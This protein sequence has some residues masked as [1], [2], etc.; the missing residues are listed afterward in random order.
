MKITDEFLE[1]VE[2][3][4]SKK[5]EE[6]QEYLK[7][8]DWRD[9]P[10]DC[11]RLHVSAVEDA[12]KSGGFGVFK[13]HKYPEEKPLI[14]DDYVVRLSDGSIRKRWFFP[15]IESFECKHVLEWFEFD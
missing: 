15:E 7:T 6:T 4:E 11:K 1:K 2:Q 9:P 3:I 10:E 14:R 13:I 12:L 5:L 8:H